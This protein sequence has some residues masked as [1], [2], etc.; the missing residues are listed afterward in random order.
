MPN[1]A[2][3]LVIRVMTATDIPIGMRLKRQAG[4]NQTVADWKRFL[5]LEPTGCFVAEL[6]GVP[7][8]TVT[9]CIFDTVAWVSMVLVDETMRNRGIGTALVTKALAYLDSQRIRPVRLDATAMGEPL[10]RKLGFVTEYAVVR[11]DGVINGHLRADG[12]GGVQPGTKSDPEDL[13]R[14]DREVTGTDRTKLLLRLFAEEPEALRVIRDGKRI[15]GFLTARPG[16][17][18]IQI[19]PCVADDDSGPHLFLDAGA[20]YAGS[21]A[22]IDIPAD[23][24]MAGEYAARLGL[25][26]KRRLLRMCRGDSCPDRIHNLWAGAGLEKG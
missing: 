22:I 12:D 16:S 7:A 10:Y 19:G 15:A 3:K 20:R 25:L 21:R 1:P 5:D 4:W 24:R 9:T 17:E 13:L 14:F 6:D 8:G 2:G 11:F 26:P 18:A 23:N